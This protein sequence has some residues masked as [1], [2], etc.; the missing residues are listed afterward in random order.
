MNLPFKFAWRYIFSKKSTNAIN[1]ISGISVIGI[2]LGSMALV[3]IMSVFN[4]FEGLLNQLYGNFKPDVLITAAEG[5]VFNA[6]DTMVYQ[7]KE[8]EGVA[9]VS[10][11]LEEIILV[12]YDKRQNIGAVKGVDE[13]FR[14]LNGIDTCLR[15]GRYVLEDTIGEVNYALVGATIEHTL[16]VTVSAGYTSPVTVYMPKRKKK[17]LSST[18]KPFKKRS[19]YPSAVYS[20]KEATMDNFLITNLDFVRGLTDY[21][22]DEVS[23]L[24][25]KLKEEANSPLVLENIK[26]LLGAEY[27]V[28][29]RYQQDEALYKI[30]NLEKWV[31][32]LIF[33]FTLVLVAFNMVGALWM[34]V[35]EK[36]A[37]IA[38]LKS[39]GA[40]A[41][42]IRQ[43][44][45]A[46]GFLLSL[47]GCLT[48]CVLGF[49]LCSLQEEFG[50]VRFQGNGGFIVDAYPVEMR[51]ADFVRVIFT[52][53]SIGTIAAWLPAQ[54]ASKVNN[55]LRKE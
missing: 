29:N 40:S 11:T 41:K 27:V 30:T 36:K 32:F 55:I 10:R 26:A 17:S 6:P 47:L 1:I 53:L 9:Y 25:L 33:A 37:D 21:K 46:E 31:A 13:Y 18:S 4:G 19:L 2:G 28:K 23:G 7:L 38:I 35:L 15:S 24:E 16:G 5:K 12:E 3:T 42:I 34:L 45:I 14:Y 39:M 49:I 22:K 48:G 52:V 51:V 8:L 44:F 54:R 20:V 43:I 50:L